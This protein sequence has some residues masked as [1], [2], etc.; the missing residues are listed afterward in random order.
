MWGR[1]QVA[2]RVDCLRVSRAGS[3]VQR[4]GGAALQPARACSGKRVGK[5][6][7][8]RAWQG[9]SLEDEA[10]QGREGRVCSCSQGDGMQD[11][12][13][14]GCLQSEESIATTG[15]GS[16]L[17]RAT[18]SAFPGRRYTRYGIQEWMA[19]GEPDR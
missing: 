1:E 12:V 6:T 15:M 18:C 16:L 10:G 19:Q 8:N 9:E 2:E 3:G 14:G 11:G 17:R 7:A 5:G 4:R 13:V